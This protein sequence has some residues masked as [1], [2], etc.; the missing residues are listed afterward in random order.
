M[1]K[2]KQLEELLKTDVLIEIN[3]NIQEL[4]KAATN[5]KNKTA[6]DELKYMKD[7]KKYFDEVVEDIEKNNLSLADAADILEGLEDMRAENQ[8]V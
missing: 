3:E 5:K 6:K 1:D 8:E 2:I 7:V 4:E